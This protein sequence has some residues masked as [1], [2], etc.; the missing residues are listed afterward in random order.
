MAAIEGDVLVLGLGRS[1][2]ATVRYLASLADSGAPLSVTVAD[3]AA[4]ETVGSMAK[5][6]R[7]LGAR[8]LTG[9]HFVPGSFDLV[10]ASPG[11]SPG[12]VL[13]SSARAAASEVISEVELAWRVSRS[14]WIAIT[15]TNGKTTVTALTAH[16]LAG[17]GMPAE[18]VGNI[19]RP[20]ISVAPDLDPETVLVAEVSSFQLALTHGF[21][22][23]VAVLLN[24]TPDHL[25]WH[26]TMERYAADK[27]RIFANLGPGDVAV[28]DVDDPGSAPW[29]DTVESRGVPVRRVSVHGLPRGGAGLVDGV[30]TIDTPTGQRPVAAAADLRI[31]GEHNVSNALAACAAAVAAGA[32]LEALAAPLLSF[33]PIEHRLEPAG[34]ADGVEYFDDSKATNPDSVIKA[35]TAFGER[36]V[37]VL[38][39]GRNKGNDF[40]PL[41]LE[42]A[43]RCRCAVVFGE[44][45]RELTE[46]FAD[47]GL[48]P[49]VCHTMAEAVVA[50]GRLAKP[51]G[52]VLLSPGCASFDE[53]T[54]YEHRGRAFKALVETLA[55]EDRGGR[56]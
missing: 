34:H 23:R 24:I 12:S 5:E 52:V 54:D 7:A 56:W 36:D 2:R 49:T 29:A 21:H 50:A 22:P 31:R 14:P 33:E 30:L 19:G 38:L 51:G 8:V 25:D 39:G 37:V 20:A 16:L 45:A 26:G 15:G 35:L 17:A 42:V 11:I 40:R 10:V 3:E 55:H 47:S 28:I 27:A 41:A 48:E 9:A 44:S 13:I 18:T 46:A 6:M 1:G 4:E 32:D 53:F 43:R